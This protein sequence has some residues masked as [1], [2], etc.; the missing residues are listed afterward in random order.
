M[1]LLLF[2][3]EGDSCSKKTESIE[4]ITLEK[5]VVYEV[6]QQAQAASHHVL[7]RFTLQDLCQQR[8]SYQQTNPM[9]YI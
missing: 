7:G 2:S 5:T 3:I 4:G 9:Y 1:P 8:D 6:W